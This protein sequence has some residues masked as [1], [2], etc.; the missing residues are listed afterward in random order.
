MINKVYFRADGNSEIGLG[1][2]VRCT[3][4]AEMIKDDFSISF[5]CKDIPINLAINLH[6]L[7]FLLILIKNEEEFF[8]CIEGDEII[9]LDH[10]DLGSL[11]QKLL[12]AKGSKLVCIDD[13][14]EGEFYAD[15]IINFSPLAQIIAYR[16]QNYTE[17]ALGLDY[18]LLR[19]VFLSEANKKRL[20][21]TK[22]SIFVCMGGSDKKNITQLIVNILSDDMRFNEMIIVTGASYEHLVGL[23][24]SV[25][26]DKRFVLYHSIDEIAIC[27]LMIHCSL[28]IVPAS[29]ILIEAL[30]VDMKI[31]SGVYAKNQKNNFYQYKKIGAIISAG[32]F[33]KNEIIKAIDLALIQDSR[34][35]Q[36]LI[37][38][39]SGKRISNIFKSFSIEVDFSVRIAEISD[40]EITLKWAKDK[41]LRR[42]FLNPNIIEDETH[43]SWFTKKISDENCFYF[44]GEFQNKAISSIRFDLSDNHAKISY[45]V[46]NN[47]QG[48]GF[49]KILLKKAMFMLKKKLGDRIIKF[50]GQVLS[51]N[52]ASIK[53]FQRLGFVQDFDS[54]SNIITFTKY[55]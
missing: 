21:R 18:A 42:Y 15:L 25:K 8:N 6:R 47:Y 37:D 10:Y 52:I 19:P 11:Y 14:H 17:F 41:S 40:I 53:T 7:E 24:R 48:K 29:G 55:Y 34:N 39:L 49:G 27:A 12:K 20:K 44:I 51:A 3:A 30:S 28:A 2:L 33:K 35:K 50:S 45:I 26:N 13:L 1:H 23:E 31:I 9:V 38:G 4:L 32:N 43:T 54:T 5:F 22:D 16:H 46:D 36:Y